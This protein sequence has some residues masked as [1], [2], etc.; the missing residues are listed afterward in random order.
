MDVPTTSDIVDLVPEPSRPNKI[1]HI[2]IFMVFVLVLICIL[3]I[4]GSKM[5]IGEF[6]NGTLE[7]VNY[8]IDKLQKDGFKV[9]I[10]YLY[11]MSYNKDKQENIIKDNIGAFL[12]T[13]DHL[14]SYKATS[15]SDYLGNNVN[16]NY[17]LDNKVSLKLNQIGE[18]Y[19]ESLH[20]TKQ[21]L[22]YALK[23]NMFVWIA[24]HK[25]KDLQN[26][27][28][29][30]LTLLNLGYRNVGITLACY[31]NGIGER[32]DKILDANG[33]IRLVKGYYKDGEI[34]DNKV[35]TDNYVEN[36]CKLIEHY[37]YHQLATHD[38]KDVIYPLYLKYKNTKHDLETND[39]LEFGFFYNSLKHV[40]YQMKSHKINLKHKC[41]LVTYGNNM[42]YL[43][44][45]FRDVSIWRMFKLKTIL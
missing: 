7:K 15:M 3:V 37:G 22:D 1:K 25:R 34:R 5:S 32:V 10:T 31:H 17:Y 21:I 8:K 44:S 42:K 14:Y 19:K 43:R 30:Y 41:C 11:Y 27:I 28:E 29:T 39:Y 40:K 45:N 16:D 33:T 6:W 24:C 35:I 36:A 18:N 9:N 23:H 4:R 20:N 12:D 26:E 2:V 38:F 13:I